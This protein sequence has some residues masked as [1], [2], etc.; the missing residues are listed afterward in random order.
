[1][2]L[3]ARQRVLAVLPRQGDDTEFEPRRARKVR[4]VTDLL[5]ASSGQEPHAVNIVDAP[6]AGVA[7]H[8]RS[9]VL[10]TVPALDLLSKEELTALVAHQLGDE[11]TSRDRV[12]SRVRGDRPGLRD[13]AHL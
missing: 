3:E 1:M 13:R 9:V 7:L 11:S 2:S 8:E 6:Q 12:D 10:I 4:T 5:S